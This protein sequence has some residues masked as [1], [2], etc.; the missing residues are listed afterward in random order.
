[1]VGKK[2]GDEAKKGDLCDLHYNDSSASP[3][4]EG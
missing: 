2:L 3:E 4:A 1:V